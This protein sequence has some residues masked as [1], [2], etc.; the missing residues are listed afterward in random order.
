MDTLG[1]I[2]HA[3]DGGLEQGDDTQQ[4]MQ[5]S[6]AGG[7]FQKV[8]SLATLAL[9][10]HTID[11]ALDLD[12]GTREGHHPVKSKRSKKQEA[13]HLVSSN[14]TSWGSAELQFDAWA[15]TGTHDLAPHIW[16]VQEHHRRETSFTSMVN[17]CDRW[18]YGC[19]GTPAIPKNAGTSAGVAVLVKKYIAA[20]AVGRVPELLK[21]RVA[22]VR[23]AVSGGITVVSAYLT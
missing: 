17:Q 9:I 19:F 4:A 14:V 12:K 1:T 13:F 18:G 2:Q 5:I 16:C 8:T 22:A 6:L 11:A 15:S 7:G 23:A 20:T 3:L 21:G 10:G